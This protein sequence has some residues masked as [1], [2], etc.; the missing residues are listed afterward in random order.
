M[1]T[2]SGNRLW[3]SVYRSAARHGH[4]ALTFRRYHD[5]LEAR[6]ASPLRWTVEPDGELT[7]EC[8]SERDDQSVIVRGR[9][10]RARLTGGRDLDRRPISVDGLPHTL[11]RV[12]AGEHKLALS[13]E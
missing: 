4:P 11:V 5:F 8:A 13:F 3:K 2:P 7:V 9:V 10:T 12:P 1:T 6:R